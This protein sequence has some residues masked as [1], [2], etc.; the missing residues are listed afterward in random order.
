MSLPYF[1]E[2]IKLNS[3]YVNAYYRRGTA[4]RKLG[5]YESSAADYDK[6]I[7]SDPDS[8]DIRES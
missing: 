5:R 2:A 3:D 8:A 1:D 7:K 6:A 4:K